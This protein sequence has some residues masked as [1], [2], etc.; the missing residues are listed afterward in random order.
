[1]KNYQKGKQTRNVEKQKSPVL[2]QHTL[3]E[4][5]NVKIVKNNY[6]HYDSKSLISPQTKNDA[7]E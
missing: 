1:M 5:F 6:A 3:F 7:T 4:D 2:Y